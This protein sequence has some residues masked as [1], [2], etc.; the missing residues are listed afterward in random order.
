MLFGVG[1]TI[2]PTCRPVHKLRFNA[3]S[4]DATIT[5]LVSHS[6]IL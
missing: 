4:N 3:S 1:V 2:K 6:W 5:E